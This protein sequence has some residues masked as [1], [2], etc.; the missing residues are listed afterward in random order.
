MKNKLFALLPVALLTSAAVG[1]GG[2]TR[3]PE[4]WTEDTRQVFEAQNDFIKTCYN[5]E[6]K[7]NDKLEGTVTVTFLVENDTGRIKKVKLD[8]SKTTAGDPARKCVM[9]N[10]KDLR[11]KPADWN[12]GK[13]SFTWEFKATVPAPVETPEETPAS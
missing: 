12:N 4:Q 11:V 10:I 6:L 7:Q 1:C 3:T 13:G 5:R 2:Y 9:D 8:D